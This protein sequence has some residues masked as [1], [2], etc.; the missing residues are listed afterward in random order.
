ML[1]SAVA[2][3]REV[4]MICSRRR[5]LGTAGVAVLATGWPRLLHAQG[6]RPL[7]LAHSV[8]TFVYGQHLVAREKKFFEDEGVSVPSFLVPGGGAKVAQVDIARKL[9]VAIWHMLTRNESFAPKGAAFRLA[10]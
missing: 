4:E 6:P 9:T 5:F 10:A 3:T 7:T 2:T 8:S 1:D